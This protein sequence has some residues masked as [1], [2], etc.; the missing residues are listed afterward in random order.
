MMLQPQTWF[1]MQRDGAS[2]LPLNIVH[3]GA[4]PARDWLKAINMS[5]ALNGVP[6]E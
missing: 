3:W 6:N 5:L 2:L 1:Q 4:L